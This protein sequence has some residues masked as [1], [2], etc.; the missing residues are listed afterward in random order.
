MATILMSDPAT[1]RVAIFDE[2]PGGGDPAD[3]NALRNRPLNSPAAWLANVRFHSDFDYYQVAVGPT[4]VNINHPAIAGTT[5]TIMVNTPTVTVDGQSVVTEHTLLAHNLGYVPRFMVTYNGAL[6]TPG[7]LV[8]TATARS[9]RIT[10][11]ATTT[12]IKLFELGI[13]SADTLAAVARSYSVL[14]FRQPT[15]EN[16]YLLDFDPVSGRVI[17][18]R[19]KFDSSRKALRQAA[20]GDSPFDIAL[21]PTIDIA[22]GAVRSVLPDGTVFSEPL[23]NGSFAGSPSLQCTVG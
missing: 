13:S 23:Y 8:Q 9:R 12:H 19:G 22:N 7:T 15:I 21:G 1:G 18:G 6:L 14:V 2:A 11:F 5:R 16:D 20:A 10:P 3:P 4:T 17:I